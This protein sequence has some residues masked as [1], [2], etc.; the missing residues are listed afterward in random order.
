MGYPLSLL[1]ISINSFIL[2]SSLIWWDIEAEGYTADMR[3]N[4]GS[5]PGS[6]R[7]CVLNCCTASGCRKIVWNKC[8]S[9]FRD[10][11]LKLR[12]FKQYI[13]SYTNTVTIK[14]QI[15]R[16][17]S[18]EGDYFCLGGSGK[19]NLRMEFDLGLECITVSIN[20]GNW[21]LLGNIEQSDLV[22]VCRD[23]IMAEI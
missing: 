1:F 12:D 19:L 21:C 4:W 13:Q 18:K 14:F 17:I 22:E 9:H 7:A 8:Y 3:Q 11:K 16:L 15:L 6:L 20:V 10:G 5:V 23:L 2:H